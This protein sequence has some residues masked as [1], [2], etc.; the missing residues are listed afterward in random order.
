[1][2]NVQSNFKILAINKLFGVAIEVMQEACP[3]P[4]TIDALPEVICVGHFECMI[5]VTHN[6]FNL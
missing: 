2:L 3:F 5:T 1:M 6:T 4:I